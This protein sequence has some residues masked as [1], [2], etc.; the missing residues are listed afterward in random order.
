MALNALLAT[1]AARSKEEGGMDIHMCVCATD[2][3][4]ETNVPHL[5]WHGRRSE[6]I[7]RKDRGITIYKTMHTARFYATFLP[8]SVHSKKIKSSA[9][10]ELL[11]TTNRPG[12]RTSLRNNQSVRRSVSVAIFA[13][14]EHCS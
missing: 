12:Y 13:V 9:A 6:I 5:E 10:A 14:S 4:G 1:M 8:G 7:H 11:L 2:R 3:R